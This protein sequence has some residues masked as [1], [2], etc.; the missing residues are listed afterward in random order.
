MKRSPLAQGS[1]GLTR[2]GF[3][4]QR[5]ALAR[6][7]GLHPAGNGLSR[8]KPLAAKSPERIEEDAPGGPWDML[9]GRCIERDTDPETGLVVCRVA[10][11]WGGPC[12]GPMACHHIDNTGA[13]WPRICPLDR[14]LS[15]CNN[16]HHVAPYGLHGDPDRARALGLLR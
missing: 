2:S 10:E 4:R 5:Q 13:G 8:G 15:V 11:L 3:V 12:W 9:R 14:L 16:G 7:T 1:K 6:A